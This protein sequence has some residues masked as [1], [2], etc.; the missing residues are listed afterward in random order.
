MH[1]IGHGVAQRARG[2]FRVA[3]PEDRLSGHDDARAGADDVGDVAGVDA[4][5]DLD[6][7][8]RP[9]RVEAPPGPGAAS[10]GCAE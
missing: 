5:V 10:R 9:G 7:R 6:R 8:R 4:T 2:R 3:V 1:G